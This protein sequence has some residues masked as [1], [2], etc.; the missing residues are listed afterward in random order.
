MK[1]TLFE[2][3]KFKNGKFSF[4]K[5][6]LARLSC[7]ARHFGI[8]K[9]RVRVTL[10]PFPFFPPSAYKKGIRLVIARSVEND[11][12]PKS[13]HKT[14]KRPPKEKATRER[15]RKGVDEAILLNKEGRVTEG[16]TSNIFLVKEKILMTPPLE[17]GVLSG[18]TRSYVL[19]LARRLKIKTRVCSFGPEK[20]FGAEEVFI[21]SAI[22]EILP[23]RS[24]DRIKIGRGRPG[25]ITRRLMTAYRKSRE[26]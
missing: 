9:G 7:S 21:T 2:T 25:P 24:V 17:E 19:K 3:L 14:I 18:I 20:L 4:L 26:T 1:P 16:A 5:E 15:K 22:K 11:P 12:Y 23:V 10:E 8:Q 6:H 13:L